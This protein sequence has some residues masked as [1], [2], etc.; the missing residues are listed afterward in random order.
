M[1]SDEDR[2]ANLATRSHLTSCSRSCGLTGSIVPARGPAPGVW[3]LSA[4]TRDFLLR[5]CFGSGPAGDELGSVGQ[6]P[7]QDHGELPGE[8][9]LCLAH[10]STLGHA[11]RPALQ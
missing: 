1:G 7:V 11:Y 10:A 5:L 6:H 2:S 4:R 3:C 9:H 8:R